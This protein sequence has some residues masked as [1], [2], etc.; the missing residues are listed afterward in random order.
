MQRRMMPESRLNAT[1]C[2]GTGNSRREEKKIM[3][4]MIVLE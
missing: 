1:I 4:L 3:G 2:P